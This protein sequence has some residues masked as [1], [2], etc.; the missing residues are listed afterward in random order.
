M[1]EIRYKLE[2]LNFDGPLDLLL[3]LIEKNKVDIYDIPIAEITAQYL[4]YVDAIHTEDLD[5]MSD[6]LVMAATLLDIKA[7]MLLPREDK[8]EED[9][10]EDPREELVRR[11]LLYR[12]FK[13]MAGELEAMEE[14]ASHFIYREEELP[15]EV[16][17]H[18]APVD[19]DGLLKD[20]DMERLREIFLEVMKRKE[21]RRDLRREGFR[22]IH[23]ER[24]PVKSRIGS[25]LSYARKNRR[26][27]FR[28]LLSAE[29]T[30]EDVVVTFLAILELMK[31]GA[32]EV[33]QSDTCG[34]IE[35]QASEG[36]DDAKLHFD[37]IVDG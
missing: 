27:S 18:A 7:R 2:K 20:L 21:Y 17:E 37:D 9:E 32:I 12:R 5:L 34:D 25:L 6:F 16:R 1:E 26:F 36:V 15:K 31:V 3:R 35:V 33:R 19:L 22:V 23:R 8:E 4:A 14:E 24:M 28:S 13:Y 10:E 30:R 11:L 29:P